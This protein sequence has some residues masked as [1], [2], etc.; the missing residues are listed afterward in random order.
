MATFQ[1]KQRQDRGSQIIWLRPQKRWRDWV[2]AQFKEGLGTNGC[3]G[4]Q[5]VITKVAIKE[6]ENNEGFTK[7]K[8]PGKPWSS[9]LFLTFPISVYGVGV[10]AFIGLILIFLNVLLQSHTAGFGKQ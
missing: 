9:E 7:G 4:R 8:G 3:P 1:W 10:L 2:P 6:E 5:E